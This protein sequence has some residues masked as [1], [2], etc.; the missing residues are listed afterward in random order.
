MVKKWKKKLFKH[1]RKSLSALYDKPLTP[2]SSREKKL[3]EELKTTFRGFPILE[4]ADRLP[5]E[6]EWFNR[7][8]RL[9]E[10]ILNKDP[11]EFLRWHVISGTMFVKYADYVGPELNYLKSLPDW[12][13]RWCEAIK[14]SP[15]GHPMPYWRC[16]KSSGNLIHNAYH[17]AQFE[18]KTAISVNNMN[19]I[20]EFGG[21]YGSMCRLVH[22]LGFQGK[23]V[24]F[25]FP[26]FSAL[27][28]FFLKSVRITVH[29]VGSFKTARSGVVCISDVEELTEILS[30][31]FEET[32]SMFIATWSI[33]EA[34]VGLRN[35]ILPLTSSFK[36]FLIAYL[37][38]FKEVNNI[39]FFRNWRTSQE[40]I[41]WHDWQ[42][43]HMSNNNRYI[44]GKRKANK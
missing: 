40:D 2:P 33:S 1:V 14:E 27:Q 10:L 23:Y 29:A 3:V 34:P 35:L 26:A 18:E 44:V 5:S 20:F 41:E 37:A 11:R 21:G 25:D 24:L 30:N 39:D 9:R 7:V 19:C 32:D 15:I 28:Q 43:K 22:N 4:T 38:Q 42:I 8:N 16:P 31:H 17:L 36:G 13:S 6:K 12:T